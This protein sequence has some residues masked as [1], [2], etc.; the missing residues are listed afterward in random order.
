VFAINT[1]LAAEVTSIT[2]PDGTPPINGK[3]FNNMEYRVNFT[4]EEGDDPIRDIHIPKAAGVVIEF[5][6][7]GSFS[8]DGFTST[9][10][11]LYGGSPGITGSG[12]FTIKVSGRDGGTV[13][14]VA[15]VFTN[16]GT[17]QPTQSNTI[18]ASASSFVPT[19]LIATT[20]AWSLPG[21]LTT[22]VLVGGGAGYLLW[23][24]G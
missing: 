4:W 10:A 24:R 2:N 5:P 14:L 8:S 22:V 18:P 9:L 19:G 1:A 13:G 21:L 17:G 6:D 11:S 16:N 3:L 12:Y 23:R 15:P 7:L 20:P